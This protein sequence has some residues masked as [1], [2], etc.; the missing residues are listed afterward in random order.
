MQ[1]PML[2][3]SPVGWHASSPVSACLTVHKSAALCVS[4][5]VEASC[6]S[7]TCLPPPGLC[8]TARACVWAAAGVA[9]TP[10][11]LHWLSAGTDDKVRLWDAASHRCSCVC[12]S[13]LPASSHRRLFASAAVTQ[14]LA[15]S[16]VHPRPA[17]TATWQ[18]MTL[19]GISW[20]ITL[21]PSTARCRHA[22]WRSATTAACC[23][24]PQAAWS[25]CASV[26]ASRRMCRRHSCGLHVVGQSGRGMATEVGSQQQERGVCWPCALTCQCAPGVC[27]HVR[28]SLPVLHSSCSRC[29]TLAAASCCVRCLAV[30]TALSTAAGEAHA[31]WIMLWCLCT[32]WCAYTSA[33][34][35]YGLPGQLC[36]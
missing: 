21:G 18:L 2:V 10:D 4:Q 7:A 19:A 8:F 29:M 11:G 12:L 15:S 25:R 20:C 30:T 35:C 17:F 13:F 24:T 27:D 16:S 32:E 6:P 34:V 1:R 5:E 3:P 33:Q 31:L 14:L 36:S 9:P 26:Q 28:W 23:S 22:S